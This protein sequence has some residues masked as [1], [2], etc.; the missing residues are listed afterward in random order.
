[1][2]RRQADVV[3]L[4]MAL[5]FLAVVGYQMGRLVGLW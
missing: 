5:G 3:A 4:L 1:M 2:R